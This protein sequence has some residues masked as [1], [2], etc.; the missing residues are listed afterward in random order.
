M[1]AVRKP[2]L[3]AVNGPAVRHALFRRAACDVPP[4]RLT[5]LPRLTATVQLGGG[6]ELALMVGDD[7]PSR[8][9]VG[10]D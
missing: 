9:R 6:F 3:A 5:V 7:D 8:A 1:A 4:R 10:R 2:V